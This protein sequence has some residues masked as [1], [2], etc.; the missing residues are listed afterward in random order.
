[1][2]SPAKGKPAKTDYQLARLLHLWSNSL[3]LEGFDCLKTQSLESIATS[4]KTHISGVVSDFG[5][6]LQTHFGFEIHLQI[7]DALEVD[8]KNPDVLCIL[9]DLD[10]INQYLP[11][12]KHSKM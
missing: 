1:M 4:L 5:F 11:D 2:I 6:G 12:Y 7:C 10:D 9:G 8:D 3:I